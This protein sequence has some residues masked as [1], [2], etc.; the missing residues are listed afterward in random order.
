M[1]TNQKWKLSQTELSHINQ[2]NA[3]VWIQNII[4]SLRNH[5][6]DSHEK[7]NFHSFNLY[8]DYSNSFTLSIA[9]E[10]FLSRIP[11]NHIRNQVQEEEESLAVAC[12][13]PPCRKTWNLAFS[14]RSRAVTAKKCTKKRDA[15]AELLLCLFIQ[16]IAFLTFS[17]S[18]PLCYLKVSNDDFCMLS[19]LV[20]YWQTPAQPLIRGNLYSRDTCFGPEGV[21]WI[22]VS[23]YLFYL[24]L[25][26]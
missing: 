8:R 6:G 18:S 17:L 24:L 23:L 20:N 4:G 22:E 26:V 19:L 7:V 21:P 12:L 13:R 11:R 1:H 15:H 5:D 16:P 25:Q 2:W 3:L 10:V 9:S 14:C